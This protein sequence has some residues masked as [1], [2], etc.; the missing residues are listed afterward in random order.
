MKTLLALLL[1]SVLPAF[2]QG[3]IITYFPTTNNF[4]GTEKT[5]FAV[6]ATNMNATIA[7][8]GQWV[9]NN[10]AAP[11]VMTA[12][13]SLWSL[14]VA[15]SNGLIQF[16]ITLSNSLWGG[17]GG[18]AS[19]NF[20]LGTSNALMQILLSTSNYLYSSGGGGG[21]G[22]STNFVLSTSNVLEQHIA[23]SSNTVRT[24]VDTAA[25]NRVAVAAGN[26]TTVTTNHVGSTMVF[27]VNTLAQTNA[28]EYNI[29][30]TNVSDANTNN[31][32]DFTGPNVTIF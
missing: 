29:G 28:T 22:A 5:I 20:V 18:G 27:T 24:Y 7:T 14:T 15:T 2:G 9:A 26:N 16:S 23:S 1:A 31:L 32:V 6:G 3:H 12:S 8:V 10:Y 30:V 4:A 21:G 17:G 11:M 19:T 13:N 25:S